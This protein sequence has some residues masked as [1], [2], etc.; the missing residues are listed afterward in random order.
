[1][2]SQRKYFYLG[3]VCFLVGLS[4]SL[5]GLDFEH[6]NALNGYLLLQNLTFTLTFLFGI[7]QLII[8]LRSLFELKYKSLTFKVVLTWVFLSFA[9]ISGYVLTLVCLFNSCSSIGA[10]IEKESS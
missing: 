3:C 1:M 8:H 4:V 9:L 10:F 5:F 2:I 7:G 6:S